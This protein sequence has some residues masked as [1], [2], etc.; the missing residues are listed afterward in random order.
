MEGAII[1]GLQG[2]QLHGCKH[3]PAPD[4][5][6]FPGLRRLSA[7][8]RYALNPTVSLVWSMRGAEQGGRTFPAAPAR[9]SA[10][11]VHPT[12]P[13]ELLSQTCPFCL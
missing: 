9:S 10:P 6:T 3:I 11:V 2:C 12:L 4:G 1:Q 7:C 8:G 13:A 5:P